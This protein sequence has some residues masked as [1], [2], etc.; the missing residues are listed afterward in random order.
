M[1]RSAVLKGLGLLIFA[2]L[3][4]TALGACG[5]TDTFTLRDGFKLQDY[6]DGI[7]NNAR[8]LAVSGNS[9]VK[10]PVITYVSAFVFDLGSTTPGQI[11]NALV[12]LDGHGFADFVH[13]LTTAATFE[14]AVAPNGV[15]WYKNDLYLAVLNNDAWCRLYR[16]KN[17][18]DF[19]LQKK[20]LSS[21]DLEILRD[22]LPIDRWHGWKFI[23]FD[24]KGNLVVPIGAPANSAFMTGDG[25]T[26]KPQWY[27]LMFNADN[28]GTAQ[29]FQKAEG[30]PKYRFASLYRFK[31]PYT[32]GIPG[33]GGDPPEHLAQGVRNSV[34][35]DWHPSFGL[36]FTD[37]GR[38]DIGG[39][40][41]A[42]TNNS[43]DDELNFFGPTTGK[44]PATARSFGFPFCHTGAAGGQDATPYTR[45]TG[46][47]APIPDPD[48]NPGESNMKCALPAK[49]SK[50]TTYEPALQA[51]GP[52]VAALGMRFY[53]YKAKNNFPSSWGKVGF[54]A[55]HGSW[56]RVANQKLLYTGG[57]IATIRLASKSAVDEYSWFVTGFLPGDKADGSGP[58][59]LPDASATWL[60]RPVDIEFLPDGSMIFSDD[61]HLNGAQGGK[62]WRVVY[63]GTVSKSA[64]GGGAVNGIGRCAG[65]TRAKAKRGSLKAP[66]QDSIKPCNIKLS[67]S[68][69]ATVS[70][71]R[72]YS[73][74]ITGKGVPATIAWSF[75]SIPGD[76]SSIRLS[77]AVAWDDFASIVG[78]GWVW[79]GL[80]AKNGGA[81]TT[82]NA[83]VL[84]SKLLG[85]T[86]SMF[87]L[88]LGECGEVSCSTPTADA[89]FYDRTNTVTVHYAGGA[90]IQRADWILSKAE[91]KN[92]VSV[93]LALGDTEFSGAYKS[94]WLATSLKIPYSSS[95]LDAS[96]PSTDRLVNP[97]T[98]T[99]VAN[100]SG[101]PTAPFPQLDSCTLAG[102]TYDSCHSVDAS[103][104][105]S[106]YLE[107]YYNISG[108]TAS[109]AT[110]F[111]PGGIGVWTA[112]HYNSDSPRLM[113]SGAGN[114]H[115]LIS[116]GTG[117]A[118]PGVDQYKLNSYTQEGWTADNFFTSPI[119]QNIGSDVVTTFSFTFPAGATSIQINAG[120]GSYNSAG[121][122]GSFN[123]VN[124]I[125]T[126][127]PICL[128]SSGVLSAV[129]SCGLCD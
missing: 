56:N 31:P 65:Y 97:R 49:G 79:S 25:V 117:T 125:N 1:G 61:W 80:P 34:G 53:K 99:I 33:K 15:A 24:S 35:F 12:D 92:T 105:G 76:S 104:L 19:A 16:V 64:V 11:I 71:L 100:G 68:S 10:G 63:C 109:V 40:D 86:P 113:A 87:D 7:I 2:S 89:A 41:Q 5:T 51:M 107:H 108:N 88:T 119:V 21:P 30:Y 115:A 43:P 44:A 36:Y 66:K 42:T 9:A 95:E 74:D 111:T 106:V 73:A 22:D 45:A 23:R 26:N 93:L 128:S 27:D 121:G 48:T 55:L 75:K 72:C 110:K 82:S 67:D 20:T 77:M 38:D 116:H 4:G 29:Q 85:T 83:K 46:I 84:V 32:G 120:A 90:V 91:V 3:Q 127:T 124:H 59:P 47:G 62:V 69:A 78:L 96:I 103:V 81:T 13:P 58:N 114:S 129:N 14:G 126:P 28:K 37:N 122:G 60:G 98:I 39:A 50:T 54:V 112:W 70:Y 94:P 118:A 52:H 17:I 101:L 102:V 123:L 57:R 6:H 8:S 18:D